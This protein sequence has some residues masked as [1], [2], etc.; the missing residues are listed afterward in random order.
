MGRSL[1]FIVNV[2]WFF[3]SHRLPIAVE[4]MR[5]GYAVH[6][7]AQ[8]TEHED[9]LS[10]LGIICHPL[11]I[12]RRSHG[13][14]DILQFVW[15]TCRLLRRLRPDIV[16]L[17]TIKPVIFG[18]IAARLIR[19]KN[20]VASIS[21]LGFV[22]LAQGFRAR[23]RRAMV[24]FLYR[25]ALGRGNTTVIVQNATDLDDVKKI[26]SR[27][28]IATALI[29]GS[30]VDLDEYPV[31][32]L[33]EGCYRVLMAARLL[34]D[35]GVREYATAARL[36]RNKGL[37]LEFLLAGDTDPGNPATVTHSELAEL[38][39]E[40]VV[41][42][43]GHTDDM[44]GLMASCHLIVLPSYRE[45]LPKVLI[46]A[47]ACGRAIVTTDVPGCRDAI[48]PGKTGLLAKSHDATSL[49]VAIEQATSDRKALE[50]M[51][52]A[53]RLLAETTFDIRKVVARHLEIYEAVSPN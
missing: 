32:D 36:M 26:F 20:V 11:T 9:E 46:E 6:L 2:D 17:V 39:E 52:K 41:D 27:S 1:L 28:K 7:A 13:P 22:F 53:G 40:G 33:P 8:M 21:G 10:A 19:A 34:R 44:A 14:L 45:G 24:R 18:G 3:V 49:A 31:L 35:K 16:H 48:L 38:K 37:D 43:L 25:R 15:S 42:V 50:N 47:A 4:A 51:G 12:D 23:M 29:K 5:R 30:G